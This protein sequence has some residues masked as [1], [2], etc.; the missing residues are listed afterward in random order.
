MGMVTQTYIER[1]FEVENRMIR[2]YMCSS[3][4][5]PCSDSI[6]LEKYNE[7]HAERLSKLELKEGTVTSFHKHCYLPGVAR[8][9]I[10]ELSNDFLDIIKDFEEKY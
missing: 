7:T 9:E 6:A 1:F 4:F 10:K 8:G 2:R 5:C 3:Q